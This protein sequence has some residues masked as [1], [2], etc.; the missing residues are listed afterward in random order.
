M[1][2]V[3]YDRAGTL[4]RGLGSRCL[5]RPALATDMA[6]DTFYHE[7]TASRKRTS[8]SARATVDPAHRTIME[9]VLAHAISETTRN[10]IVCAA[11]HDTACTLYAGDAFTG[12]GALDDA[13]FDACMMEVLLGITAHYGQLFQ[14]LYTDAAGVTELPADRGRRGRIDLIWGSGTQ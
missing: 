1:I 9:H 5:A 10:K 13:A 7:I 3:G 4:C 11:K 2:E 12:L 6:D 8:P 14:A